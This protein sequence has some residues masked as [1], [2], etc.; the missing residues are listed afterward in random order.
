MIRAPRFVLSLLV[1]IGSHGCTSVKC[2]PGTQRARDKFRN[3]GLVFHEEH[4]HR[5]PPRINEGPRLFN[6]DAIRPRLD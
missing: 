1:M 5:L 6:E 3:F 2:G 4:S